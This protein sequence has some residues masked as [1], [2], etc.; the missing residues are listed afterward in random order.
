MEVHNLIKT[1]HIGTP[2]LSLSLPLPHPHP[3]DSSLGLQIQSPP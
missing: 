2:H 3:A 1:S